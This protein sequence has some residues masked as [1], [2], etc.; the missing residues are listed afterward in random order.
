[1]FSGHSPWAKSGI[2]DA[3]K[4]VSSVYLQCG[5]PGFSPG[6]KILWKKVTATQVMYLENPM[7]RRGLIELPVWSSQV[8]RQAIPSLHPFILWVV[9][10]Y[11]Y[12]KYPYLFIY[13]LAM[14]GGILVSPTRNWNWD[15]GSE[16]SESRIHWIPGNSPYFLDTL[17]K[18]RSFFVMKKSS[19]FFYTRTVHKCL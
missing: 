10:S 16:T 1:M 13:L 5:N 18:N 6:W 8:R 11:I 4:Q 19:L 7:D 14:T 9:F 12:F 2:N 15:L 17:L 3:N